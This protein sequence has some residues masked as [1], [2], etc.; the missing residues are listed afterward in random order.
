MSFSC[1][2]AK[3]RALAFGMFLIAT[4]ISVAAQDRERDEKAEAV[5]SRAVSFLGGDKYL[6]VTSQLGRGRFSMIRDGAVISFQAFHDVIVFPDRE[7]TEFKSGKS[8][9]VQTNVGGTGWVYDGDIETI[10][11]QTEAQLESFKRGIRVSLDNLLRGSWRKEAGLAYVGRRPSTLGKRNDVIKLA[12][13][14]GLVV[15]FEFAA[16]DGAPQKA[17][18]KRTNAEGEETV[19]EDRYAQFVDTG[20]IR[21][22]FIIDRFTNGSHTSRINY[23]SVEYNGRFPDSTFAKP[24]DLKELK[25]SFKL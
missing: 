4:V 15:E 11:D 2:S 21:S 13:D 19:E 5:V 25:K 17:I 9:T 12:Y 20:G 3:F 24:A 7:R 8:R 22:P 10:K 14:D 16:D 6:N 18:Y 1:H 23:Q